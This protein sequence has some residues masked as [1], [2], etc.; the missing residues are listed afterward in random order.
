MAQLR[1]ERKISI[2]IRAYKETRHIY[3]PDEATAEEELGQDGSIA[4]KQSQDI[5]TQRKLE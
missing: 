5:S 4:R 1:T 2:M 3:I